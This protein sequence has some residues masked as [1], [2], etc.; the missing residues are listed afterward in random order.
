MTREESEEAKKQSAEI[1]KLLKDGNLSKEDRL[2]L[3]TLQTQLAGALLSPWL[4]FDWW[5]RSTMIVCFL[6]GAIGFVQGNGY[7]LF[8]WLFLLLFSPRFVGEFAYALGRFMAGVNGR[9]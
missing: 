7:F 4:P 9:A 6:V 8:A 5:R 2:K 1:A 3:E